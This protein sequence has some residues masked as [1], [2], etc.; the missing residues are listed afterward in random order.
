MLKNKKGIQKKMPI[1]SLVNNLYA[2]KLKE[3]GYV[4]Y[5][6]ISTLPSNKMKQPD[7][8]Y[9]N[10][11]CDDDAECPYVIPPADFG[12]NDEYATYSLIYYQDGIVT[13]ECD[14]PMENIDEF[15]GLGIF[16]R[17]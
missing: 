10:D 4:D 17:V 7:D 9:I 15:I 5:S 16:R 6:Q 14:E 3:E 11:I 12:E 8:D 13:D 2:D 1:K